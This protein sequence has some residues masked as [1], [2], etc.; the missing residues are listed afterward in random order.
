MDTT[1]NTIRNNP[2]KPNSHP[3]HLTRHPSHLQLKTHPLDKSL[4]LHP[5]L[6]VSLTKAIPPQMPKPIIPNTR[7]RMP[8]LLIPAIFDSNE[9]SPERVTT[10]APSPHHHLVNN[11]LFLLRPK[12]PLH[13]GLITSLHFNESNFFLSL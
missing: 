3:N 13:L 4:P 9:P 2:Q 10:P 1:L 5:Q 12:S 11:A 7:K 8:P 6:D